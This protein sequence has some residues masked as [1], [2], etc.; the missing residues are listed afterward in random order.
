TTRRRSPA[1]GQLVERD[2]DAVDAIFPEQLAVRVQ[3][4]GQLAI[5]VD[6]R[7]A[8]GRLYQPDAAVRADLLAQLLDH[9]LARDPGLVE[10]GNGGDWVAGEALVLLAVVCERADHVAGLEQE[11]VMLPGAL[12]D[13]SVGAAP[14]LLLS[15]VRAIDVGDRHPGVANQQGRHDD[16]GN[17]PQPRAAQRR[18]RDGAEQQVGRQGN[19]DVA[20]GEDRVAQR[21]DIKSNHWDQCQSDQQDAHRAAAPV[22]QQPDAAGQGDQEIKPAGA[23]FDFWLAAEGGEMDADGLERLDQPDVGVPGGD[24]AP[25]DLERPERDRDVG[26]GQAGGR[27]QDRAPAP[28]P[29]PVGGGDGYDP[30]GEDE[31]CRDVGIEHRRRDDDVGGPEPAVVAVQRFDQQERREDRQQGHD[32]VHLGFLRIPDVIG[33][34][35]QQSGGDEPDLASG[36][37][38][39]QQ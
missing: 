36:Q 24:V 17:R 5:G 21:D 11:D 20:I 30:G 14:V 33:V 1:L 18:Q 28:V 9:R 22:E 12:C 27:D 8:L 34:D 23:I 16:A 3:P 15:D 26:H 29:L 2:V 6:E 13:P 32:G 39:A 7:H 38:A 10:D 31:N 37:S 35:R 4:G 19:D 25:D